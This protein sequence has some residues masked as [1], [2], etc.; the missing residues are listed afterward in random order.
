MAYRDDIDLFEPR[1][2][3]HSGLG[4]ASFVIALCGA[5]L[6][7]LVIVVAGILGS[8]RPGAFKADSSAAMI[9]GFAIIGLC[10]AML[11]GIVLGVVALFQA[12]RAK[13]FAILGLS[14]GGAVLFGMCFLMM[15]G[16]AMA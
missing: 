10:L 12:E 16:V 5:L 3:P 2:L 13:L 14:I 8:T 15:L 1:P 4:I 11:V 9:L 6:M 7:V